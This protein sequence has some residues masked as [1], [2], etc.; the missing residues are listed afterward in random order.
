MDIVTRVVI[1]G[2][3]PPV[4]GTIMVSSVIGAA[5]IQM[6]PQDGPTLASTFA[7]IG[8]TLGISASAV[9]GTMIAGINAEK[10]ADRT[11]TACLRLINA[12]S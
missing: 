1:E 2:A 9:A 7:A 11:K 8:V 6:S 12:H 3:L 4:A 5:I 10:I